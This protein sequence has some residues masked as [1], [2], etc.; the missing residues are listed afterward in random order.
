MVKL[1]A[2]L[3]QLRALQARRQNEDEERER[4]IDSSLYH[5]KFSRDR[6][7]VSKQQRR[8]N[9]T[10]EDIEY[11]A[12]IEALLSAFSSQQ[13]QAVVVKRL[14]KEFWDDELKWSSRSTLPE[15]Q[16]QVTVNNDVNL[17]ISDSKGND[18]VPYTSHRESCALLQDM[19]NLIKKM[20]RH[21]RDL[22]ED[23][24]TYGGSKEKSSASHC[25]TSSLSNSFEDGNYNISHVYNDGV[26]KPVAE[27]LRDKAV[28]FFY[29]ERARR[30]G[31][32]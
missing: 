22:D 18:C 8:A 32:C 27:D 13:D 21:R 14:F 10:N 11:H 31:Q 5:R 24:E 4:R 15:Y 26:S 12:E 23:L 3:T 19:A 29:L 17:K 20:K 28:P 6:I 1:E 9:S 16:C 30:A 2:T 25:N 7:Y